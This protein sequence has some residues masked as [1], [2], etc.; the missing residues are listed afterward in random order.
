VEPDISNRVLQGNA[1]ELVIKPTQT[2]AALDG[3]SHKCDR[4]R[5]RLIPALSLCR[6]L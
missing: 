3:L 6:F 2:G 1:G 4:R 5:Q